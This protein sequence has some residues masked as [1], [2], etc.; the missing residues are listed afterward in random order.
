M[1]ISPSSCSIGFNTLW[2][3]VRL[4]LRTTTLDWDKHMIRPSISTAYGTHR[5]SKYLIVWTHCIFY[6]HK[7]MHVTKYSDAISSTPL[8]CRV[9]A[10]SYKA[11]L[12]SLDI[13]YSLCTRDPRIPTPLWYL[14]I[15]CHV[16]PEDTYSSWYLTID[17]H[18]GPEDTYSSLIPDHRLS[19]WP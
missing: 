10:I 13:D 16:G 7:Q 15:D 14:T 18:V 11:T 3:H 6:K 2:L 12:R 1:S 5:T 4:G 8:K 9:Q 19:C 17:C